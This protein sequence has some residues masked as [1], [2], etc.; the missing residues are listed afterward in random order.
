MVLMAYPHS[1]TP[2]FVSL[3]FTLFSVDVCSVLFS[4]FFYLFVFLFTLLCLFYAFTFYFFKLLFSFISTLFIII[5]IITLYY[6]YCYYSLSFSQS[7][8]NVVIRH[9]IPFLKNV[10]FSFSFIF[11]LE[12][13]HE[14]SSQ[15]LYN[16]FITTSFTHV[17]HS[18]HFTSLHTHTHTHA[19]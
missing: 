14:K 9:T 15:K 18:L 2:L 5:I 7:S 13:Q 6:R 17:S 11:L 8:E 4:F 1:L 10:L 12:R 19:H 16:T 3:C